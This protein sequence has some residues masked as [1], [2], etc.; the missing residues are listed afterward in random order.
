MRKKINDFFL[1]WVLH[2]FFLSFLSFRCRWSWKFCSLSSGSY[3]P[4]QIL[5]QFRQESWAAFGENCHSTCY[6]YDFI[7]M[8]INIYSIYCTI[9]YMNTNIFPFRCQH[10]RCCVERMCNAGS[11]GLS[12]PVECGTVVGLYH[13]GAWHRAELISILDGGYGGFALIDVGTSLKLPLQQVST[14]LYNFM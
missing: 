6:L 7:F 11:I 8:K 14:T 1:L 9:F 4:Q 12:D 13:A 10:I 3:S 2:L 5:R